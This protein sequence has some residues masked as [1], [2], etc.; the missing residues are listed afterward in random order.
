MDIEKK[1]ERF[2]YSKLST[3][4]QCS[5][6]YKLIY[7][8]KHFIQQEAIATDFGTL[9]HF[10]EET[11][12][13]T[14]IQYKPLNYKELINLFL[15]GT[16]ENNKTIY[17]VNQLKEKY[18]ETFYEKDK[19]NL[20]YEDKAN[21]YI[22]KGIY[23][24]K[25]FLIN[26]PDFDI[27]GIEQEF[28]LEYQGVIF[29]GVIDRVFKDTVTNTIYIE[30]I[31]TY[32]APINETELKTPLQFV[33]YTL[34]AR[35]LYGTED[36]ICAY[37]L[38]LI[39]IKQSAG[40]KGYVN[41]GIKKLDKILYNI[42]QKDFEPSPTPLCHWCVFSKTYPNQPE[43][44]K[45]LC[46]YYSKWTRENKCFESDYIWMGIE[47]HQKILEDFINNKHNVNTSNKITVN[48]NRPIMLDSERRFLLR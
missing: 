36:I 37:E 32:S 35:E 13:K 42:S 31:K 41:R 30:D 14:I 21:Y 15:E 3:Y 8:D 46:P 34:A 7:E 43:E 4:E 19:N 17:G 18:P 10:I 27:I 39:S 16:I 2:S 47:N 45:N 28:S 20:S 22:N 40:T 5:F 23:R 6:K 12:A 24:L 44:A 25:D 33:M 48:I 26:N 29:H 9:V 38:P 1:K 11:M